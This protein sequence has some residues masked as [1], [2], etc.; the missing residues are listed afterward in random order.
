MILKDNALSATVEIS[1]PIEKV[2]EIW[3][4]PADILHWN[5]FSPDWHTS[6]AENDPRPGGRFLFVMGLKDGSFSFNFE[7]TYDEVIPQQLL[8]YTL[9]D[10]RR[11]IIKFSGSNP[12]TITESFEPQG[13]DPIENQQIACQAVLN[14]LKAYVE[15]K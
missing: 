15:G 5:S 10:G 1:A 8:A 6:H 14:N 2:W 11:S 9:D 12:V 13:S 7:G 3:H 4:N